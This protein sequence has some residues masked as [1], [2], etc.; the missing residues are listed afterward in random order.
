[1]A[2]DQIIMIAGDGVGKRGKITS[3]EANG[4]ALVEFVDYSFDVLPVKNLGKIFGP[5]IQK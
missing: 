4:D 3:I 1:M 5:M 2:D